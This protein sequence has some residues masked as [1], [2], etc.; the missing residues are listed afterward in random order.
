MEAI[1]EKSS[2]S[3]RSQVARIL[4][5]RASSGNG[6]RNLLAQRDIADI[7]DTTWSTVHESLNSLFNEGAIKIDG[8]RIILNK[9]LILKAAGMPA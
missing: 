1:Q 2:S 3:I 9:D 7:L 8:R 4:L 5:E 6:G